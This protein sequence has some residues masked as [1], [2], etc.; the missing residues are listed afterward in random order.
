MDFFFSLSIADILKSVIKMIDYKRIGRRI[1]YYRKNAAVT[2]SALSERL[3]VTESYVSQIERGS[4]KVSLSRLGQIAEVLQIDTA[5]L[6]SD[7]GSGMEGVEPELAKIISGW[8]EQQ[9]ALLTE[10]VR[11]ADL[12]IKAQK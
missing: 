3:G 5:L 12:Q 2:Q 9:R 6:I 10:L 7:G 1:A 4:A 8:P 11:C